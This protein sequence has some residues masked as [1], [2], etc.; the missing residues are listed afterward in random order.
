M[1]WTSFP[2][3]YQSLPTVSFVVPN[4]LNG[5]HS[6]SIAQAGSWLKSNLDGYVQWAKTHNSLLIV[7]WDEDDGSTMNQIPTFFVGPMVKAGQYSESINHYS[8]LHT[9]EAMYGLP[10]AGKSANV[11]A[12]T[13][14]WQ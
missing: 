7:T 13:D 8:V 5:M 2:A 12:I 6:G 10:Y 4:Q 14:I 11:S 9:L 1:P 3:D